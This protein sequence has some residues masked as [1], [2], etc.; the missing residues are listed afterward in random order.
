MLVKPGATATFRV[1]FQPKATG[2]KNSI[3][4]VISNDPDESRFEISLTGLGVK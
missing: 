1:N 2:T 4:N 3:V